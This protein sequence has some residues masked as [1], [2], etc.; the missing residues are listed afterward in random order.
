[1]SDPTA[2]PPVDPAARRRRRRRRLAQLAGLVA[3]VAAPWWGPATLARLDFF[4]VRAVEL[5]GVHY[6]VPN[7]LVAELAIDTARSVWDDPAPL[8][9]RLEALPQVRAARI[10]RR[11]PATLVVRLEEEPPVAL[12][13]GA[14][15]LRPVDA[16]G[17]ELPYDPSRT[18]LDLPVLPEPD[19][20][21]LRLL[22]EVRETEPRLFRR[23]SEV[24]RGR[25]QLVVALASRPVRAA[26]DVTA[27][28][29]AD[30]LPVEDDLVRRGVHATELD[31]RF[32]D[33]V[34]A[35]LP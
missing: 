25:D 23:I 15:G 26:P 24:R 32:R 33:Q 12:V 9:R 2:V 22:V 7:E 14:D 16:R 28:R 10:G 13:P 1:M 34:I 29:L 11:L 35:R 3:V 30:V 17:A 5:H 18:P 6:A 27:R 21:L 20:A 31:L 8:V 19:T 4:H